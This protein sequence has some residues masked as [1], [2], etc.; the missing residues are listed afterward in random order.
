MLCDN[1]EGWEGVGGR[2]K[3]EGTYVYLQLVHADMAQ[4]APQYGKYPAIKNKHKEGSSWVA[5]S[6]NM[7]MIHL[8]NT[9][10]LQKW[11][12]LSIHGGRTFSLR[13]RRQFL[14]V[15]RHE[16]KDTCWLGKR[17]MTDL[18]TPWQSFKSRFLSHAPHVSHHLTHP[19]IE[20]A[21]LASPA[22]AGRFF[23]TEPVGKPPYYTWS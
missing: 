8:V 19:G 3:K 20:P 5:R 11:T 14:K 22:L 12:V 21:S 7:K 15:A 1:L 18:H 9:P 6:Y 4:K 16:R 10:G 23:T 17:E 13:S 2:F